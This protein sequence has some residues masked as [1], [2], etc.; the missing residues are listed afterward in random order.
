MNL[1]ISGK[2]FE[3]TD[4][5]KNYA[6]EKLGSINR[7]DELIIETRV[8]IEHVREQHTDAYH[9]SVNIHISHDNLH[10]D[11]SHEDVYAAIDIAKDEAERLVRDRKDKFEAKQR[12]SNTTQ[13][14]LKSIF[15]VKDDTDEQ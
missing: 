8:V 3:F 7:L 4:A 1:Q 5:I 9:I 6:E 10:C 13:R 15:A 11:V 2:N 14:E 12:K